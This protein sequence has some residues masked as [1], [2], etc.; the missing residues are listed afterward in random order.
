[1]CDVISHSW[2]HFNKVW[3]NRHRWIS[4]YT[5]CLLIHDVCIMLAQLDVSKRCPWSSGTA[6]C[7]DTHMRDVASAQ[8]SQEPTAIRGTHPFCFDPRP[9]H[10][11][12]H[13]SREAFEVHSVIGCSSAQS[14]HC[15]M[16]TFEVPSVVAAALAVSRTVV[17]PEFWG[18]G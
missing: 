11:S 10:W 12:R 9:I 7:Y 4:N 1:M 2:L 16:E 18:V 8:L 15:S 14:P 13:W 17:Y 5:H 3:I 6:K